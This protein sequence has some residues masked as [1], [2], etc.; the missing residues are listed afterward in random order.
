MYLPDV[1][2]LANGLPADD[3][4]R[5][6]TL[7]EARGIGFASP[8]DDFAGRPLEELFLRPLDDHLAP[9]GADL[10]ARAV[11]ASIP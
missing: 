1:Y 6:R 10:V 8:L 7:A 11:V 5:L 4:A 9:D 3:E 2:K